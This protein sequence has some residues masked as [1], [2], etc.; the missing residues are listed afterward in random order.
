MLEPMV[1]DR[2]KRRRRGSVTDVRK[3]LAQVLRQI[4]RDQRG[5]HPEIWAR[6]SDIVGLNLGKR[7]FPRSLY[8]GTLVI[9]VS[10]SAWMNELAFLKRTLLERLAEEVGPKTVKEIKLVLDS[11]LQKPTPSDL[12]PPPEQE[13]VERPLPREI[14]TVVEGIRDE[15]L[16]EIVRRAARANI[17]PEG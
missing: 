10:S 15:T 1:G 5:V 13:V 17:D 6:W 4:G 16:R 11:S 7:T 12:P 3:E 9:A 8:R 14:Q 2:K